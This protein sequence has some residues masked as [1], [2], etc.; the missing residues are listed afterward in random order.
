MTWE[1]SAEF[2]LN[3]II[4]IFIRGRGTTMKPA[5]LKSV[6]PSSRKSTERKSFDRLQGY[7]RGIFSRPRDGPW[8]SFVPNFIGV[9]SFLPRL[10]FV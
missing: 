8:H 3:A 6:S 9:S 5:I 7:I 2:R 4:C 10:I 1:A